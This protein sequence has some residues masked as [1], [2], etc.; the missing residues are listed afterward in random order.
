VRKN[1]TGLKNDSTH[2]EPE[3]N[4][5]K[6]K[7]AAEKVKKEQTPVKDPPTQ[8]EPIQDEISKMVQERNNFL[9]DGDSDS[10]FSEDG[11]NA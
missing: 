9:G 4:F 10:S 7:L 6:Q 2:H 11:A 3:V 5:W 8:Q 1:N